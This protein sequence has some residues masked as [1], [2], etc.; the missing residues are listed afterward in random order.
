ML[1]F[2]DFLGYMSHQEQIE[3]IVA[4]AVDAAR[5]GEDNVL[6]DVVNDFTES[7]L[8]YIRMRIEEEL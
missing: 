7:E 8:D 1:N 2:N 5:N 4:A 6:V 3:S